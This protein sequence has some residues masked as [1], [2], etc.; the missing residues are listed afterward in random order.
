MS[1]ID[2]DEKGANS[3]QEMLPLWPT[4]KQWIGRAPIIRGSGA[5]RV[6][7]VGGATV[8]HVDH[9]KPAEQRTPTPSMIAAVGSAASGGGY[10]NVTI[11]TRAATVLNPTHNLAVADLTPG[12][13]V[14][15]YGYNIAEVGDTTHPLADGDN[16]AVRTYRCYIVGY[17]TDGKPVVELIGSPMGAGPCEPPP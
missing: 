6:S 9:V 10:Y 11:H 1:L 8:V 4:I 5:A 13:G 16:Q 3:L 2:L 17:H 15:G 14:V 7:Q 12:S